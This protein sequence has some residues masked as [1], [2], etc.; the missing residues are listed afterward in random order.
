MK[1]RDIL[2]TLATLPVVGTM[3]Y[4][5][6]RKKEYDCV[7]SKSIS[8]EVGMS[9][10]APPAIAP[11]KIGDKIIRIGLIGHGIRGKHLAKGLE[12]VHPTMIDGWKQGTSDI[13]PSIC[14]DTYMNFAKSSTE[15]ILAKLYLT[16]S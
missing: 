11:S 4:G 12:F 3:I 14:K 1:R 13:K 6:F 15:D 7:I 2:K 16:D 10:D 5:A 9:Y 8:G